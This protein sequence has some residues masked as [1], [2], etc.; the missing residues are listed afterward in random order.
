M[1]DIYTKCALTNIIFY[2]DKQLS[3]NNKTKVK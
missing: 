3:H 2:Y 1:Y